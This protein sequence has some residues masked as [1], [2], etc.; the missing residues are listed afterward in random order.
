MAGI[1]TPGLQ[2][3]S[4]H[5]ARLVN[6]TET[7][8]TTAGVLCRPINLLVDELCEIVPKEGQNHKEQQHIGNEC[9]QTESRPLKQQVQ[10]CDSGEHASC[11]CRIPPQQKGLHCN[12]KTT[13]SEAA[14]ALH[15]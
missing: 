4:K 7:N 13:L 15:D 6:G 12:E 2:R 8:S 5:L 3:G 14:V 9:Q 1:G 11:L 10:Q